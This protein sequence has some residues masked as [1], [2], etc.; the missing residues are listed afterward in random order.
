MPVN[1][2][3][4]KARRNNDVQITTHE[5]ALMLGV[6]ENELGVAAATTNIFRGVTLPTPVS[7][8]K[9]KKRQFWLSDCLAF[10][11]QLKGTS[12]GKK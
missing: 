3:R 1:E 6:P 12:A 4:N 7:L 9:G 10:A 2:R 11:E 5:F 8:L